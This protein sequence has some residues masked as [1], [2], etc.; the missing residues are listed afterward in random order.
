MGEE[1]I[2]EIKSARTTDA[3]GRVESGGSEE[4]ESK[5]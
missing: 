4:V 1:D 3:I 2:V 5:G